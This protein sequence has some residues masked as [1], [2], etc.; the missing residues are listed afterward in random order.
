MRSSS[1]NTRRG[2]NEDLQEGS[3]LS[4]DEEFELEEL[5]LGI[6]SKPRNST[7]KA[8]MSSDSADEQ[9]VRKNTPSFQKPRQGITGRK[10]F[11]FAALDSLPLANPADKGSNRMLN[12]KPSPRVSASLTNNQS[13]FQ[14]L[15]AQQGFGFGWYKVI[16]IHPEG[17]CVDL[18]DGERT[19]QVVIHPKVSPKSGF[20]LNEFIQ[21]KLAITVLNGKSGYYAK[22][23]KKLKAA[24]QPNSPDLLGYSVEVL[25]PL[26][27]SSIKRVTSK[28]YHERE[29]LDL[30]ELEKQHAKEEEEKSIN[31]AALMRTSKN[32][33][34]YSHS[35]LNDAKVSQQ[36][37]TVLTPITLDE[38]TTLVQELEELQSEKKRDAQIEAEIYTQRNAIVPEA[39]VNP[40]ELSPSSPQNT[41][42]SMA[43]SG[44]VEHSLSLIS[45]P[46][47]PVPRLPPLPENPQ[48]TLAS[49]SPSKM[50]SLTVPCTLPLERTLLVRVVL[51]YPLKNIKTKL[52][53]SEYFAVVVRDSWGECTCFLYDELAQLFPEVE[54]GAVLVIR[55]FEVKKG[56]KTKGKGAVPIELVVRRTDQAHLLEQ[57]W[58]DHIETWLGE[59]LQS[60]LKLTPL[61]SLVG[62]Y[63]QEAGE[64]D[65]LVIAA[66]IGDEVDVPT[67]MGTL[68]QR[69]VLK[70]I[71]DSR[72][73]SELTIW[74]QLNNLDSLRVG[75]I[76]IFKSVRL[77]IFRGR[78]LSSGNQTK[79]VRRV[80]KS[81]DRLASTRALRD[82]YLK[83]LEEGQS[84]LEINSLKDTMF[85]DSSLRSLRDI[86][87]ASSVLLNLQDDATQVF[88]CVA[89]VKQFRG[90]CT[91]DKC[92]NKSCFKKV[93]ADSLIKDLLLC[94]SCGHISGRY[95]E[96]RYIGEVEIIDST[97]SLR[98][99]FATEEVGRNLFG[100]LSAES[101][102]IIRELDFA[103]YKRIQEGCRYQC[104]RFVIQAKVGKERVTP[105]PGAPGPTDAEA[106]LP[107][108]V[109]KF[110]LRWAQPLVYLLPAPSIKEPS[111]LSE[112]NKKLMKMIDTEC[113]QK[114]ERLRKKLLDLQ[115][116][117]NALD[118]LEDLFASPDKRQG[119][120]NPGDSPVLD[121]ARFDEDNID[122]E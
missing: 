21:V 120:H 81:C 103:C 64:F 49:F 26:S 58:D 90:K 56:V 43:T 91:Y 30:E 112:I 2:G 55:G 8:V 119:G 42:T 115:K 18:F 104:F 57:D 116:Q 59:D 99:T 105:K 72:Y 94:A 110:D 10:K 20:T 17:L 32:N 66:D 40:Q 41:S 33:L 13:E 63:E 44:S 92:P 23:I 111:A 85:S 50:S 24:E 34:E 28:T 45:R 39:Q 36:D 118:E 22:S 93:V 15:T 95:P 82:A 3:K 106:D 51:K 122:Y 77:S 96:A 48:A 101:F 53:F 84:I 65:I 108:K 73:D 97:Y 4:A 9:F 87:K 7:L 16:S 83:S 38:N 14:P 52:G 80:P 76:V 46:L 98:C 35:K 71:D 107:K 12:T 61:S 75:D 70:V 29:I 6:G 62:K 78:N 1:R 117:A 25:T 88:S 54:V 27:A 11:T 68:M 114:V 102:K 86:I 121:Y 5:S 113:E 100:G 37:P 47:F 69:R 79:L 60:E 89:H 74:G 109:L 67:K 31:M 19:D